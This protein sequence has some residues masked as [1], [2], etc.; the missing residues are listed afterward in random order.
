MPPWRASL[1]MREEGLASVGAHVVAADAM[2]AEHLGDFLGA[3]DAVVFREDLG[4]FQRHRHA[5][6]VLAALAADCVAAAEAAAQ[7]ARV[8]QDVDVL[9][10]RG[11]LDG[12]GALLQRRHLLLRGRV[13]RLGRLRLQPQ[14]GALRLLRDEKAAV[15]I[16]V[17][18]QALQALQVD[19]RLLVR[20][21]RDA[22]VAE[23]L[24]LVDALREHH[25]LELHGG[26][27]L[28][29]VP[30]RAV[31]Y[32]PRGARDRRADAA[33]GVAH[34][35]PS[36]RVRDVRRQRH[37]ED[38]VAA[39][40][41]RDGDAGLRRLGIVDEAHHDRV[42]PLH[43]RFHVLQHAQLLAGGADQALQAEQEANGQHARQN[44]QVLGRPE[45]RQHDHRVQR[46]RRGRENLGGHGVDAF[47]QARELSPLDH[48]GH[49]GRR[50]GFAGPRADAGVGAEAREGHLRLRFVLDFEGNGLVRAVGQGVPRLLVAEKRAEAAVAELHRVRRGASHGQSHVQSHSRFVQGLQVARGAPVGV[51]DGSVRVA[52][53]PVVR[54]GRRDEA[55]VDVQ[56][57]RQELVE[58]VGLLDTLLEQR[59]SVLH[60]ADT[61]LQTLRQALIA[62][63]QRPSIALEDAD[64]HLDHVRVRLPVQR[65]V[66]DVDVGLF[67]G[68]PDRRRGQSGLAGVVEQGRLDLIRV[69]HVLL[70]AGEERRVRAGGQLGVGPMVRPALRLAVRQR[71]SHARRAA[72]RG[73]RR[74]PQRLWQ[75]ARELHEIFD[76]AGALAEQQLEE[77]L[78]DFYAQRRHGQALV[79][80]HVSVYAAELVELAAVLADAAALEELPRVRLERGAEHRDDADGARRPEH[81]EAGRGVLVRPAGVV[82]H[83]AE[84]GRDGRRLVKDLVERD[85][86]LDRR[87]RVERLDVDE[88]E[89]DLLA[90]VRVVAAAVGAEQRDG[91]HVVAAALRRDGH[92]H[93][94]LPRRHADVQLQVAVPA[95]LEVVAV[96][97]ARLRGPH[98][99]GHV[100]APPLHV[101]RHGEGLA[102]HPDHHEVRVGVAGAIDG[103]ADL[104]RQL[105]PRGREGVAAAVRVVHADPPRPVPIGAE[106]HVLRAGAPGHMHGLA[107]AI[108]GDG[109][110]GGGGLGLG[111][112]VQRAPVLGVQLGDAHADGV[113]VQRG[114]A[115]LLGRK[116]HFPPAP[117]VVR[118]AQAH[119]QLSQ[120]ADLGHFLHAARVALAAPNGLGHHPKPLLHAGL[121]RRLQLPGL[122]RDAAL[123]HE[124]VG[125][126]ALAH[127]RHLGG[128]GERELSEQREV[129]GVV[130]VAQGGHIS[131]N[132][133]ISAQIRRKQRKTKG[134]KGALVREAKLARGCGAG[135]PPRAPLLPAPALAQR[136]LVQDVQTAVRQPRTEVQDVALS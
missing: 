78:R 65:V 91:R 9:L 49:Q 29:V 57:R 83:A 47:C 66:V 133:E 88:L 110:R 26:Q 50:G 96:E 28:A 75:S 102:A 55:R 63:V 131:P 1:H 120:A 85:A 95:G 68:R 12:A 108:A 115:Q 4:V 67:R 99:L 41:S 106:R 45:V 30:E 112:A 6:A 121:V 69:Q 53:R 92:E 103:S 114:P 8:Q 20:R 97:A 11:V 87:R 32:A 126:V 90:A 59:R 125:V 44:L 35:A 48:L 61:L 13:L 62:L 101:G 93:R 113:S 52:P 100:Q 36:H 14:A 64:L 39:F 21:A 25:A 51:H 58:R 76:R 111:E 134:A 19:P 80:E 5:R 24:H 16:G 23:R 130:V 46:A 84:D 73:R 135:D 109:R 117:Q 10:V 40:A 27:D 81:H 70:Q 43:C 79:D 60:A 132:D 18:A 17:V 98:E 82:G 22:H 77:C 38:D 37:V 116:G 118:L 86:E 54:G 34:Q 107:A 31:R 122:A 7:A 2:P 33:A 128:E 71:R 105:Q 72:V 127:R 89:G 42:E 129:P 15:A 56:V 136:A 94:E 119:G 123:D 124:D 3:D 74:R 104:Q